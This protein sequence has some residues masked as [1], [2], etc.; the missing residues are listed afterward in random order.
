MLAGGAIAGTDLSLA[1]GVH[2]RGS[3]VI[4]IGLVGCG[5]RGT[6]AVLDLL[7]TAG[8]NENVKLVAIADVFENNL[9]ATFRSVKGK[10]PSLVDVQNSRFIGLDGYQGVMASDADLVIL[11]TPPGFRPL[12]FEA[13]VASGKHVFMEKPVATDAPGVRRILAANEIA[14]QKNLAVAVGFQRRHDERYRQCVERIHSGAIGELVFARAYWNGAGVWVRPRT[15]EQTELEYQ[16]RNWYYFNWLSGDHIVEQH[17]HNLDVINWVMKSHPVEAQGQG[18]REVRT[19]IDHGQIFDHHMVEYSYASGA[20]MLSQCRQMQGCRASV[21]EFV[22]GT[23]GT[24]DFAGATLLDPRGNVIWK[25]TLPT[26]HAASGYREEQSDLLSALRRGETLNEVKQGAES[27]M[28]AIMGRMAT[29]TGKIVRWDEA[30]QSRTILA[31]TAALKH[32][33]DIA[34]VV[35][36]EMGQYP[37]PVPGTQKVI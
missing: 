35:P 19:G 29:Y 27:T 4:K 1:S 22:H 6:D 23:K 33:T 14:I 10:Y 30:I 5:K 7:A 31:D 15:K 24:A 9:Q 28:T 20:K 12:H 8:L 2:P 34:P 3:D 18:G 17:V 11:A 13:A 21:G 25:S 16:L 32:L 26:R 36:D 37:V